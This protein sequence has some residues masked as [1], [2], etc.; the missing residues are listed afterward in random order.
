MI[1]ASSMK[2]SAV[3]V[4]TGDPIFHELISNEELARKNARN[5]SDAL[6]G[7]GYDETSRILP[8]D[9]LSWSPRRDMTWKR[10]PDTL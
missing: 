8:S 2:A 5:I 6:V 9:R 1:D 4:G 10:R 7:S 3:N